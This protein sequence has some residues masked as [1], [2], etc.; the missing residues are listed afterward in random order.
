MAAKRAADAA[1]GAAPNLGGTMR[2][3]CRTLT[4]SAVLLLSA[5][6]DREPTLPPISAAAG[7]GGSGGPA[8]TATV[9]D[10]AT[11][12]TTL[13]VV[14]SGSGFDQGSQAQWAIAG[15]PSAKV[16]TNSTQFVTPKKLIANITIATDADTG[17]YD[18]IVTAST[19]KKGIGS[20]LFA[21]R[22]KGGVGN[23]PANPELAYDN[24]GL[25]V[26]D[27]DG[28]HE[29]V[30]LTGI[31][32]YSSPSWAPGGDGT[33]GSPYRITLMDQ[34]CLV[35]TLEVALVN[36]VP[37]ARSLVSFGLPSGAIAACDPV[38]SPLGHEIAF[39]EGSGDASSVWVMP[40]DP[41]RV[42]EAENVYDA[43]PGHAI[44]W[45]AWDRTGT[46]IA[47]IDKDYSDNGRTSLRIVNRVTGDTATVVAPG[48]M[49]QIMRPNWANTRAELAFSSSA[50]GGGGRPCHAVYTVRLGSDMRPVETPQKRVCGAGPSW[51]PDDTEIAFHEAGGQGGVHAYSTVS[52]STRRLTGSGV[53]VDWRR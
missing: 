39:G 53:W 29:T 34:L 9:P 33:D 26:V 20:E 43:P 13:D 40:A 24:L 5:C 31:Y 3:I 45:P 17:L 44:W 16:R 49:G 7:G 15:V 6:A 37:E 42:A 51:S 21:V 52:G 23:T 10:S 4:V 27:A 12:D 11:Q 50:G 2:A 30:L 28:T 14:V 22:A 1:L 18:V 8:V 41:A 38:W 47:F 32:G 25:R 46:L 36:G 19:G 35:A 48:A